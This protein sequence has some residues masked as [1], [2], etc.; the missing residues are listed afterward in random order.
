MDFRQVILK[1]QFTIAMLTAP[2]SVVF[3]FAGGLDGKKILCMPV[4]IAAVIL[5]ILAF[6][7]PS[8]PLAV[9]FAGAGSVGSFLCFMSLPNIMP[10]AGGDFALSGPV[11][12]FLGV[13]QGLI[14]IIDLIT[15]VFFLVICRDEINERQEQRRQILQKESLAINNDDQLQR[16]L[17]EFLRPDITLYAFL[18][19]FFVIATI[20]TSPSIKESIIEGEKGLW[21]I[22]AI[23]PVSVVYSAVLLFKP[24]LTHRLYIKRLSESG[25]LALMTKDFTCGEKYLEYDLVL[26]QIYLFRRESGRVYKYSDIVE[27]YHVWSD[28]IGAHSSPYWN[29][30]MKTVDEKAFLL[31][32]LSFPRTKEN[33]FDKVLPLILKIRSRNADIIVSPL[34]S[35]RE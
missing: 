12:Y 11:G 25:E 17:A 1:T 3:F 29:L 2:L 24:I 30:C 20:I 4:S 26:G 32:K 6:R 33:Y 27:I 14:R 34:T 21:I 19:A 10:W 13:L 31:T 23:M 35:F 15:C 7:F 9:F 8:S 5:L 16:D 18:L 28:Y 22:L